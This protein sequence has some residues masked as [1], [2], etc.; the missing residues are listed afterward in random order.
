MTI[1]FSAPSSAVSA[2]TTPGTE[3]SSSGKEGTTT[4]TEA[5]SGADTTNTTNQTATATT[6]DDK[7]TETT[8]VVFETSTDTTT[9]G[10][11]TSTTFSGTGGVTASGTTTATATDGPATLIIT[12]IAAPTASSR[13]TITTAETTSNAEIA[14]AGESS[15]TTA[16]D[17]HRV[18]TGTLPQPTVLWD[19]IDDDSQAIT[20][21]FPVGIYGSYEKTVY[22]G[23]NGYVSLYGA[24][25]SYTNDI[26]P[27][28]SIPSV[29]IVAY[30]TDL[31]AISGTGEQ[32]AYDVYETS[33]GRTFT[34]EYITTRYHDTSRYYHFTVSLYENHPGLVTFIYYQTTA[35]GGDG[36]IGVQHRES[37]SLYSYDT[38]SIPDRSYIEIDTSNGI[39]VTK[40]GQLID[41]QC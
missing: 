33:R 36:T 4:S 34:V 13:T 27:S 12:T 29:A 26:L 38:P 37:F 30:W 17:P 5:N 35:M 41:P 31:V 14:T 19:N 10:I 11:T 8:A 6:T 39:A 40:H 9:D 15:M 32:I 24:S 22:V 16:C 7:T 28:T 23:S 18:P 2:K 21:P 20:L 25:S 3:T 1:S